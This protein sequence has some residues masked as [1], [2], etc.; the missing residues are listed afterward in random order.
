[1][2]KRESRHDFLLRLIEHTEQT[3]GRL[4]NVVEKQQKNVINNSRSLLELSQLINLYARMM[5]ETLERYSKKLAELEQRIEK[6][7][8]KEGG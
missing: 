6:M 3:I 8:G 5:N 4:I 7:E 2:K 1:M